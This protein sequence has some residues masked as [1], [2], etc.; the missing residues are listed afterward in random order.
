MAG[1]N[2]RLW[3]LFLLGRGQSRHEAERPPASDVAAQANAAP[4]AETQTVAVRT[5]NVRGSVFGSPSVGVGGGG[6]ETSSS[7]AVSAPPP[8]AAPPAAS[9][10]YAAVAGTRRVTRSPSSTGPE[11]PSGSPEKKKQNRL[12][13]PVR[14]DQGVS[15]VDV[16]TPGVESLRVDNADDLLSS[17]PRRVKRASCLDHIPP[18]FFTVTISLRI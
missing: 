6:V 16:L 9:V 4:P 7:A 13:T 1:N 11:S 5:T 18:D 15:S 12:R 3:P 10:T 14:P 8:V 2:G 17:P